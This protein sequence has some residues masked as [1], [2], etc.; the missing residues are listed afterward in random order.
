VTL[1][2]FLRRFAPSIVIAITV[3]LCI[4]FAAIYDSGVENYLHV[5]RE[6][7]PAEWATAIMA[8]LAGLLA[9]YYTLRTWQTTHTINWFALLFGIG[10]LLIGFEEISW[11]QRLFGIETP[12]GIA[13]YNTK[14]ETNLHNMFPFLTGVKT[15]YISSVLVFIYGII[16]P[17]LSLAAPIRRTLD[18]YSIIVP[19]L[20]LVPLF[21]VSGLLAFFD[22]PTGEEEELAEMLIAIGYF[23]TVVLYLIRP[24]ARPAGLADVK[25]RRSLFAAPLIRV[26]TLLA[27]LA[28]AGVSV[29]VLLTHQSDDP[30]ILGRYSLTYFAYVLY[31]LAVIAWWAG[32]ALLALFRWQDIRRIIYRVLGAG[33]GRIVLAAVVVAILYAV[34]F[35]AARLA[36]ATVPMPVKLAP[37]VFISGAVVVVIPI[38]ERLLIA[39]PRPSSRTPLEEKSSS[40]T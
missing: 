40:L 24:G 12:T 17:L 4:L 9:L 6:D 2:R 33:H 37:A 7:G 3:A 34:S 15:R 10:C 25:D 28:L 31:S 11:G 21:F 13:R 8:W 18:R 39:R 14:D 26:G 32:L 20:S 35:A 30:A 22:Q 23:L 1:G 29:V 5:L 27:T 16:L 36:P 38:L 19:G